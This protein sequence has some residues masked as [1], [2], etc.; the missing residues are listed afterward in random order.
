MD[1]SSPR[2]LCHLYTP[3]CRWVQGI[4]WTI[5]FSRATQWGGRAIVMLT[6]SK[7]HPS[8]V[9]Q[10]DQEQSLASSFFKLSTSLR[11]VASCRSSVR[12]TL[13]SA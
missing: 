11:W 2:V 10:V 6:E 1:H 4:A 12:N 5:S 7:I 9:W 3:T 13:S 8:M